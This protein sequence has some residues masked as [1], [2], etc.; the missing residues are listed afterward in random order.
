MVHVHVKEAQRRP[1]GSLTP[2]AVGEGD[3]D[4]P[5]VLGAPKESAHRGCLPIEY[6]AQI[7]EED[8]VARSISYTKQIL[9]NLQG[10]T[11]DSP[12]GQH[13]E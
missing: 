13:S 1:D 6:G 7:N 8:V 5:E 10:T 4:I 9:R 12:C 2:C 3:I 11:A